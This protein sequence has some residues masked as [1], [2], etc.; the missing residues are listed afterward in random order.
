MAGS[1]ADPRPGHPRPVRVRVLVVQRAH[2]N[3]RQPR[4]GRT[5]R[6][7]RHLS[8]L[9]LRDSP[10]AVR[11][12]G[13]RL[14]RGGPDPRRRH[15]RQDSAT[16]RRR[17][18][19]RRALRRTP[20]PRTGA[21]LPRGHPHPKR[22]VALACGTTDRPHHD[23][24]GVPRPSRGRRHR[25]RRRGRRRIHQG[26]GAIRAGGQRGSTRDVAGSPRRGDPDQT[27]ASRLPRLRG[28]AGGAHPPD[29]LQR[30]DDG[31]GHGPRHRG[32][33]PRRAAHQCPRRP[34]PHHDHLR[35]S[36]RPEAAH[37]QVPVLRMV[38]PAL[39]ARPGRPGRRSPR[40]CPLH[41]MAGPARRST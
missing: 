35:T 37:R 3:A 40:R 30:A 15:Q 5:A 25:V 21:R 38:E 17:R 18:A 31:S 14:P 34:S 33:R 20:T 36:P 27:P 9:V 28:P 10:A 41:R 6:V 7:A 19:L 4:R 8:Q 11:R 23:P 32:A 22:A 2:R 26:H 16:A 13:L 12:G 29:P 24:T 1:G 39:P